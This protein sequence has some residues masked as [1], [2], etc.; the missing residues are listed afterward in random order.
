MDK[1]SAMFTLPI[2]VCSCLFLLPTVCN[3]E[4]DDDLLPAEANPEEDHNF[5][6]VELPPEFASYDINRDGAITLEELSDFTETRSDDAEQPF[7]SADTDGNDLLT[8]QEFQNAP[9]VFLDS[10]K[11]FKSGDNAPI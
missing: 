7:H 1:K 8:K 6:I 10:E 9:W 3:S 4:T 11:G 5:R 2:L